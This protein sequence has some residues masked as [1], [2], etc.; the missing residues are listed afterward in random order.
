MVFWHVPA[1]CWS[2]PQLLLLLLRVVLV[3]S[4]LLLL[5]PT[6]P[7]STTVRGAD[8]VIS[9]LLNEAGDPD[10]AYS[11]AGPRPKMV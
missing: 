2:D 4:L 10:G 9:T 6:L 11:Q 8:C 7:A 5:L 3:L 1:R